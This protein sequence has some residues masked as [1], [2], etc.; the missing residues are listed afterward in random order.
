MSRRSTK[1]R[2]AA[3]RRRG[4]YRAVEEGKAFWQ[5]MH[6]IFDTFR[7]MAKRLGVRSPV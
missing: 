2:R 3:Q 5:T 6:Q 1:Q 7:T 4:Y